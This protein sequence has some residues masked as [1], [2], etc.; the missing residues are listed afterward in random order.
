MPNA[1]QIDISGVGKPKMLL[2]GMG[3]SGKTTQILT[4]PGKTFAYFFDPAALSTVRGHDLEYEMFTPSVANLAVQSLT[5]GKGDPKTKFMDASQVYVAWEKD[6]E[7]KLQQGFFAEYDTIVMD[8]LTTFSELVMDR[9]LEINGRAGG[10]PQQDDYSAQ[11][12]TIKN[13]VRTFA[14]QHEMMFV[15]TGHV[16]LL[17]DGT[18]HRLMNQPILTGKLRARLPLLFSDILFLECASTDKVVKY[19]TQTRPDRLNPLVRTAIRGL[20]MHEDITVPETG[21]EH[22]TN[23]GI[24]KI[25]T[26]KHYI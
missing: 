7:D 17:Q 10:T 13:V 23:Y 12:T 5:K 14:G 9:L 4:L 2:L 25:L 22:P 1:K 8:S 26:D 21:W 15:A 16:E 6:Y 19:T 11:M 18:T 24:G 20:E 3:G